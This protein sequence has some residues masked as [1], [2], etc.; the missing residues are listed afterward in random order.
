M[1]CIEEKLNAV[2]KRIK[3][4]ALSNERNLSDIA[5][6]AVSKRFGPESIIRALNHGQRIFGEN[7]VQ[8]GIKKIETINNYL[9]KIRSSILPEWHF[10]GSLQS[11]KANLVASHFDWVHTVDRMKIVEKLSIARENVKD[12]INVCVQI[13]TSGE[14]TKHGISISQAPSLVSKIC[15][16]P[17]IKLRGFM[18]IPSPN[19]TE[20]GLR[21]EYR[22]LLELKNEL[23]THGYFLDTLSMGMSKDL[24]I[25]ISE[26][27]TM[28]RVGTA[29]FGERI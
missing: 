9:A 5:L 16:L 6:V 27:S 17:K 2:R 8:E 24:E 19:T 3:K 7:Y 18:A 23:N 15:D 14:K 26:G 25:A 22:Q 11:N 12:P 1:M 28:V 13:N 29:V 20:D 21:K 10:I 4:A